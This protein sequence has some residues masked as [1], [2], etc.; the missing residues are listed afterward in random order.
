[1]YLNELFLLSII[2]L[3]NIGVTNRFEPAYLSIILKMTRPIIL[4]VF[5]LVKNSIFYF[6]TLTN[7]F[8]RLDTDLD[9]VITI[10][11]EQF[12]GMVFNLKT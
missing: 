3:N 9:G 6:Q 10:H 8:R 5:E 12:L 1:M 7:A 4:K 2:D 11:Y